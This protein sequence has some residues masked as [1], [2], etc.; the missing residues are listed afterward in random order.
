VD[1]PIVLSSGSLLMPLSWLVTVP[2]QVSP[3]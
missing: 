2:G 1:M 3:Q